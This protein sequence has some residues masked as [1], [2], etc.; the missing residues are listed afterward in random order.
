MK[1]SII[2]TLCLAFG[3]VCALFPQSKNLLAHKITHPSE[4]KKRKADI[5]FDFKDEELVDIINMLAALKKVNVVAP[6]G[7]NAINVK[8]NLTIS[9]PLTLDEAWDMLYRLLDIAGYSLIKKNDEYVIVKNTQNISRESLPIYIN[10]AFSELPKG[11]KRIVYIYYL[12]NLKASQEFDSQLGA[13]FKELLP[14]DAIYKAD[15]NANGIILVA[16]S[17]DI[18][19]VME[20]VDAMD[21]TGFQERLELIRLR[22]TIADTV[23]RIFTE[24]ILKTA[25]STPNNRF[26]GTPQAESTAATYFSQNVRVIPE[27]RTNS[28][29]VLGRVQAVERIKDFIFKYI[30][31]QLESGRS[32]LHI[33]A[34]QYLDA[35]EFAPVLQRIVDSS[36]SGGT[37]QSSAGESGQ[38]GTERLFEKVI[39]RSDTP[40]NAS[41]EG[42]EG[43]YFGGNKLVIA[44]RN[45]DWE[46][47]R[48]LI[49]ELDKPQ[50]QVII[51]V[52]IADLTL[53]D[54]RTLGAIT[55][56]PADIPFPGNASIQSAMIEQLILDAPDDQPAQINALRGVNS[57]LNAIT[58]PVSNSS[59]TNTYVSLPQTLPSGTGVISISDSDGRTWSILQI[60]KLFNN[61]KILTH[62]HVIATNNQT[63]VI[64]VG[65]TRLVVDQSAPST[66]GVTVRKKGLKANTNLK[67]T[68]RISSANTVNLQVVIDIDQFESTTDFA[69]GNRLNRDLVTNA[70]VRSG[71]ILA[72]GGLIRN[73]TEEDLAATPGLSS[74]PIL[75]WLFQRKA[76]FITQ[77]SLNIFITPTIIQPKLRADVGSY[78]KAYALDAEE[79]TRQAGLFDSLRDPITRWF[80][81]NQNSSGS[82]ISKFLEKDETQN[83]NDN[84]VQR[85]NEEISFEDDILDNP[86]MYDKTGRIKEMLF[87]EGNPLQN[88]SL[89]LEFSSTEKKSIDQSQSIRKPIITKAPSQPAPKKTKIIPPMTIAD[90]REVECEGKVMPCTKN[91]K[92]MSKKQAIPIKRT[93]IAQNKV[94][95]PTKR[96]PSQRVAHKSA[97]PMT[98][99]KTLLAQEDNP[100]KVA[101]AA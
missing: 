42:S 31:V 95:C 82:I 35:D 40:P 25:V 60:L 53:D 92:N 27:P 68:P 98:D 23:A 47:I 38:S 91:Q 21:Q 100:L 34:L 7:A 29:I 96:G 71:D 73:S 54:T 87:T 11:D 26:R 13:L 78:T 65:E 37:G 83:L 52:L 51:E 55:R 3:F 62:P 88:T 94:P 70:S 74:I 14:S 18:R 80:F 44:A 8:I 57:D 20:I 50:P 46:R 99:L 30:D 56:N 101:P 49:E 67:I 5:V 32:I 84:N 4:K 75:G 86:E 41:D 6:I 61:T 66:S 79:Y 36:A 93:T 63:A 12:T 24:G 45:D 19:A 85:K 16:K 1:K 28:L 81:V 17:E 10:T 76:K 15:K 77:T 22:Y 33:Y 64:E 9:Q 48:V 39:I 89:P 69:N 97:M 58:V 43:K 2:I 72:L 90:K 59:G